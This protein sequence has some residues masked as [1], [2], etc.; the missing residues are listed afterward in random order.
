MITVG[1]FTPWVFKYV[2]WEHQGVETEWET[3]KLLSRYNAM[4]DADACCVGAMANAAFYQHYPLPER[5]VQQPA[6]APET[7]ARKG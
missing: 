3:V 7:L 4:L 6:P 5:L 2:G 1:G